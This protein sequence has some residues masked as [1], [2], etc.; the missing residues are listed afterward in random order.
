MTV[1]PLTPY[2]LKLIQ[3][4]T[5][6]CKNYLIPAQSLSDS[7][8]HPILTINYSPSLVF[9]MDSKQVSRFTFVSQPI[10]YPVSPRLLKA[11][12][13]SRQYRL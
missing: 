11:A 5:L 8:C 2:S 12:I 6:L 3:Q 9:T 7:Y 10:D 1:A 13:K 4:E